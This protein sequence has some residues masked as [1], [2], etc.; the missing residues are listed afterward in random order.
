L[1]S[2]LPGTADIRPAD[3]ADIAWQ[4]GE[5]LARIHATGLRRFAGWPSVF[6]RA[7]GSPVALSGPAADLVAAG[8]ETV[9]SAPAVLTHY[10]FW[11]GNTLWRDGTL[12]GVVDWSGAV[13]GP[14]GF[15]LSWCRLR[16]R[17]TAWTQHLMRLR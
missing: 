10:D 8:W 12:T 1:I 17:H 6:G 16:R 3:P 11:S 2:C 9:S 15:D 4:L 13:L 14:R 7:A 5:A